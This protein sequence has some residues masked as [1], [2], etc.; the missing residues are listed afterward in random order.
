M[1]D[2]ELPI[3]GLPGY[4][5]TARLYQQGGKS[6]ELCRKHMWRKYN[7]GVQCAFHYYEEWTDH[8]EAL[9][10]LRRFMDEDD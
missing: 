10:R 3:M 9:R 2:K 7:E 8:V 1:I 6:R 4:G 5:L